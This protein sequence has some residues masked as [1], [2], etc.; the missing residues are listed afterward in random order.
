MPVLHALHGF[1]GAGKTT[2]AKKLEKETRAVRFTP[3]EWVLALYRD[4][5][6]DFEDRWRRID[7]LIRATAARVLASGTD[8]IF[9]YGLWTRRERDGLRDFARE[10]LAEFRL[11][12]LQCPE[13]LMRDRVL[14]RTAAMP[15]GAL[16]IDDNAIAE[17]KTRFEGLRA[18]EEHIPVTTG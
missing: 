14:A 10:N 6:A 7:A 16:R 5:E 1:V 8:V 4:P 2:F 12:G 18:D 3:D 11:Y 13:G 17:F 15:D 9:D